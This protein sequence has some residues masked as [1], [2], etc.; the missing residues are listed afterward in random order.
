[1]TQVLC[2]YKRTDLCK[3]N[4]GYFDLCALPFWLFE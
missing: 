2:G 1:M 3:E 4:S